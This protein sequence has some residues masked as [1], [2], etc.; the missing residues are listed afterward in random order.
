[1]VKGIRLE[2]SSGQARN[3]VSAGAIGSPLTHLDYH[4]VSAVVESVRNCRINGFMAWGEIKAETKDI[5]QLSNNI[6]A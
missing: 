6:I 1:M 2:V 3:K 4:L 5:L